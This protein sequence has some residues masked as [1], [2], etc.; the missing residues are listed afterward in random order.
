MV[1]QQKRVDRA[2]L[3]LVLTTHFTVE[4]L[5]ALCAELGVRYEDLEG[6]RKAEKINALVTYFET[7][8]RLSELVEAGRKRYSDIPWDDALSGL[9]TPAT[10][11]NSLSAKEPQSESPP[12]RD[13]MWFG[14]FLGTLV[15]ILTGLLS[16]LFSPFI[17]DIE[18]GRYALLLAFAIS[19]IWLV[20]TKIQSLVWKVL[21][22]LLI[23]G[24]A[25][26]WG[27][28]S[29]KNAQ[30]QFEITAINT[31]D[32]DRNAYEV[33]D[34]LVWNQDQAK[35]DERGVG[36]TFTLEIVPA[37][38]GRQEHGS[39]TAFISGAGGETI[40]KELW[41]AFNSKAQS[42]KIYLT[43]SEL[44]QASGLHTNSDSSANRFRTG[45]PVFQQAKLVVQIARTADRAHPWTTKEIVIRNTP[46]EFR[47]ALVSYDNP[48]TIDVYVRNLGG[49]GW[50]TIRYRLVR[51]EEKVGS[52]ADPEVSG[53]TTLRTWNQ[54]SAFVFLEAGQFFTDTVTVTDLLGRGRYLM[55]AYA[56]K[57]QN[58]VQFQDPNTTWSNLNSLDAP[59]WF[60]QS[61]SDIHLFVVPM[62]E[63]ALD[64]A[65]IQAERER[66]RDE[67]GVDLGEPIGSAEDVTS[68][69]GFSGQRLVFENGV[70]YVH[71]NQVYA[72]YGS[73]FEY[74]QKLDG[75][76]C[77]GLEYP[78]SPIQAVSSSSG[79]SG[80]MMQFKGLN[81]SSPST[82][83]TFDEGAGLVEG[84]IAKVYEENGGHEG[85]LGFPVSD[86]QNT[87]NS[88]FQRFEYGYIVYYYQVGGESDWERKPIAYPYLGGRGAIFDVQANQDWQ[89]TGIS[90]QSGDRVTVVQIDGEWTYWSD[91]ALFDANGSPVVQFPDREGAPLPSV[92]IGSLVGKVGEEGEPVFLGRWGT[93]TAQ[94]DGVLYLVMNDNNYTDNAGRITVQIVVEPA[95]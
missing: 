43:L 4:E 87:Q 41:P 23:T 65:A 68:V 82:I 78:T 39:V 86:M 3:Q 56:V 80:E 85:W 67:L 18:F 44:M 95:D 69:V 26:F 38:Y 52:S 63:L 12:P 89:G 35:L 48:R 34:M 6:T 17:L 22:S 32:G 84:W 79:A 13:I 49:P 29:Y 75:A 25:I 11:E 76:D 21:L 66:L 46:W 60:G 50:F 61:P 54:P 93:F 5:D 94:T 1:S 2:K 47:S 45:G 83:Y 55:E 70:V 73:I 33:T 9:D 90:V 30:P 14:K 16:V 62:S 71:G 59:W 64:N 88:T 81:D 28:L 15:T 8:K 77:D 20:W 42:Q 51:L 7:R 72:I 37:Y 10:N 40:E 19:G 31:L 58:Y 53:T 92:L 27:Y 57:K 74:Y 91:I 36:I 24:I